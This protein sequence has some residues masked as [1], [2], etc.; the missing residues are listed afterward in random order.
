MTHFMVVDD[1]TVIRKVVRRIC[2]ALSFKV[3]EAEDGEQ[4]LA[5]CRDSM[6]DAVLVDADMPTMDGLEFV[7]TLRQM[8]GGEKP[9]VIYC[10]T[11]FNVAQVGK[12]IRAGANDHLLK[13]FD[14]EIMEAKLQEVG[15]L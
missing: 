5:M 13:P 7:R 4:G 6:P 8:D 14:R 12:A 3:D 11:E 9:K 15:I 10:L 2:E 1:S